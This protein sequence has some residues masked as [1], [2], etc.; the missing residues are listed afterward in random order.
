MT[1]RSLV[2]AMAAASVAFGGAGCGSSDSDGAGA[3]ASGGGDGEAGKIAFLLPDT[4]LA[5]WEQQDR[6]I[7]ERAAKAACPDCEVLIH[8]AQGDAAKQQSQAEAAITNGA[9]VLVI[10]AVDTE[11]AASIVTKAHQQGVKVIS[12]G[13][14]IQNADLDYGVTADPEDIG[15]QQAT[16]LVETLEERG[17]GDGTIVVVNG[18]PTDQA[19]PLYKRGAHSV[20]DQSSL[21][22]GK[23]YDTPNW[24]PQKAQAEMEQAIT[25][26]RKDGFVGVYS[27]NDGM[28]GG[29][30]AAMKGA[31]IDP[32]TKP[33]TGQD[34]DVAAIQ[35]ILTGEQLN[36]IYQPIPDFGA[37]A[38]QLAAAV[39]QGEEPPAELTGDVI[40]NGQKDVP[41][42]VYES[43][44]VDKDNIEDTVVKD[45]FLT[46]EQICTKAYR[47]A[48][49]DAGLL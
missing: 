22:I 9:K 28:A 4:I 20:L 36:T 24:D 40:N 44:V 34:A 30:I 2:G 21:K 16:D 15:R 5:R 32:S 48:C 47:A 41:G 7:F 37:K 49:Q 23:E 6:S 18:S 10:T 31:G 3:G 29:I 14:I 19:A 45:G 12:Y 13:R 26:L 46:V 39:A 25:G 1:K 42:Y 33:T 38:A 35:R 43:V 17:D 27:G 8:N 11:S